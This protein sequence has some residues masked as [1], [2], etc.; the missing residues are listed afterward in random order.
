MI[1][2]AL[3]RA[4]VPFWTKAGT[5]RSSSELDAALEIGGI[6]LVH[7]VD[8]QSA[9]FARINRS[10]AAVGSLFIDSPNL[11]SR[12]VDDLDL[13]DLV[14]VESEVLSSSLK[15]E[16]WE[17]GTCL[18]VDAFSPES[19][20]KSRD[21][22]ASIDDDSKMLVCVGTDSD[23]QVLVAELDKE[24]ISDCN[25]VMMH[26]NEMEQLLD[27]TD[28][29]IALLQH[30][31]VLMIAEGNPYHPNLE[32]HASASGCPSL[33]CISE[34]PRHWMEQFMQIHRD[35]I[36]AGKVPRFP[37]ENTIENIRKT[38]GLRAYGN[39]LAEVYSRF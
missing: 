21:L 17:I 1:A 31:E 16:T 25:F 5:V 15:S 39:S 37:D 18:D 38:N 30:S 35:W 2:D 11:S 27:E 20:P 9:S 14:L 22:L 4:R 12:M 3:N 6:D 32:L 7:F 26:Y 28:R 24:I 29:I 33:N 19:N 36:R 34:D 13:L 10:Y 23:F 8:P